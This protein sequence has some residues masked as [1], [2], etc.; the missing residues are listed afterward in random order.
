MILTNTKELQ[1]KKGGGNLVN[2]G[3]K[4]AMDA[5]KDEKRFYFEHDTGG[6]DP[7]R[8]CR[9]LKVRGE[10]AVVGQPDVTDN[11]SIVMT[12]GPFSNIVIFTAR[13]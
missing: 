7:P 4:A 9:L 1:L 12:H 6:H 13:S 8:V 3:N 10:R 11:V 5:D 2:V